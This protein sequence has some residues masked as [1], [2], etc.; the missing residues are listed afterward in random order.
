MVAGAALSIGGWCHASDNGQAERVSEVGEVN[1]T[2]LYFQTGAVDTSLGRQGLGAFISAERKG[3]G[4]EGRRFVIQLTGPMRPAWRDRLAQAGVSVGDYVPMNAFIVTLDRADAV[5]ADGLEFVRWFGE[6][7]TEWK[8]APGLGARPLQ[9]PERLEL[10]GVGSAIVVVSLFQETTTDELMAHLGALEGAQAHWAQP[11]GSGLSVA[12]TV[13]KKDLA[14]LASLASVQFVEDAPELT[15]RNDTDRWIVQSNVPNSTPLYQRGL[16]GEDQVLG[17]LDTR[18]DRNHCSFRDTQPI[19]PLH[20]KILAYNASTGAEFHGTHVAGTAVGDNGDSSATRGVAYMGRVVFNTIP[21]FDE[22]EMQNRLNTHHTQG[23]RVHTNS[24]GDDGTVQYN[25][26]CRGIDAF[27]RNNEDDLVL[28]AV[29]NLNSLK[30]PENAKNLVAVGGSQDSPQQED[31]CTGGT[32][33]TNDQRRKPE[34]YAPGCSTNSASAGSSCSTTSATGTSMAC[35]AIA[36]AGMLVRQYFAEGFYPSGVRQSEDAFVPSGALLKAALLNSAVDMT[37]VSG[38]PSQ[39]EGWGRVLADDALFFEKDARRLVVSDVRN[40]DGLATD[41]SI[42]IPIGVNS[43]G[44][45][46]K[47]TLAWTDQ[48]ATAGVAF[49]PVNDLDL[50]VVAPGDVLYRGNVFASGFSTT[51][52]ARDDRNNVEQV[53]LMLPEPGRYIVRVRAAASNVAAQGYAVVVTGDVGSASRACPCDW[54]ESGTLDSTD[55]FEF[56]I[57]FLSGNADFNESGETTSQDFFDF[58]TCFFAGCQ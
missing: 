10:D 53:H 26:L 28:V 47:I 9:T 32:G 46:L 52:G 20:R 7:R 4:L 17:L 13:Q 44:Q 35:P 41:E 23:A 29:T 48:P 36:G 11:I 24:W 16:H 51:G 3:D 49:A 30:K 40:A 22:T 58:L 8:L 43:N 12:A 37:G 56:V 50:E 5:A 39:R 18:L 21:S 19:G 55:F 6:F 33:P 57:S 34:L 54:D 2:T 38:Y 14:G 45:V 42:E 27:S 1:G 31:H 15:L 25:S